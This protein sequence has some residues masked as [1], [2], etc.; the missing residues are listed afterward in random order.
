MAISGLQR[1]Y[2]MF[3][4]VFSCFL[5][6]RCF[7]FFGLC[8]LFKKDLWL[9]WHF[10]IK[11][12]SSTFTLL[13]KTFLGQFHGMWTVYWVIANYKSLNWFSLLFANS[14]ICYC[15]H[16]YSIC[17]EENGILPVLSQF[18]GNWSSKFDRFKHFK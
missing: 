16:F 15:C 14:I 3:F 13:I 11:S 6:F 5:M 4:D 12:S 8:K 1:K 2:L 17:F 7:G 18:F 10:M 9:W